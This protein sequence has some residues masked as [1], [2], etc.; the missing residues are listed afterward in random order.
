MSIPICGWWLVLQNLWQVICFQQMY[1]FWV[2]CTFATQGSSNTAT[3]QVHQNKA[4]LQQSSNGMQLRFEQTRLSVNRAKIEF[5]YKHKLHKLFFPI[6]PFFASDCPSVSWSGNLRAPVPR[7]G[8]DGTNGRCTILTI[9]FDWQLLLRWFRMRSFFLE[10]EDAGFW[11]WCC[12]CHTLSINSCST[13]SQTPRRIPFMW[14][15]HHVWM[16]HPR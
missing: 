10:F 7:R 5:L 14:L 2:I 4:F 1:L 9:V 16:R 11:S 3:I 15:Q 6:S 13:S 8:S 12:I